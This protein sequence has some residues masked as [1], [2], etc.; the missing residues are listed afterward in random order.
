MAGP[1]VFLLN[2]R[3]GGEMF[4]FWNDLLSPGFYSLLVYTLIMYTLLVFYMQ[5]NRMLGEGVLIKFLW[6]RYYKPVEEERIFMFLDMKSSTTVAERLGLQKYYAL[7]DQFYHEISIPV[8]RNKAEI[9]Q[10]VG[11]EVVFTWKTKVGIKNAH[12]IE[13]FFDI[14]ERLEQRQDKYRDK[15]G[16]V[17]KFKA[18]VHFGEVITAKIG[19]LKRVIVYNGDVLNTASRIQ[20]VCNEYGEKLLVSKEVLSLLDLPDY[21]KVRSLGLVDLRGKLQSVEIFA[22]TKD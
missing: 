5:V 12:C 7:L 3:E 19:D 10:Y 6:G 1:I 4:G 11:D 2:L 17:P 14:M 16:L 9:Y 22:I 15:Y 21:I 13:I 8:L 20:S 18:G